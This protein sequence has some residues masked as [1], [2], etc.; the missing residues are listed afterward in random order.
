MTPANIETDKDG[1]LCNREDWSPDIASAIALNEN[2]S[3]TKEHWEIIYLLRDFY[4]EYEISPAMRPLIRYVEK[5]L[6]TEKGKS[7]YLMKLFPESPAKIAS[8]IAG[9]PK[10]TNCL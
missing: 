5:R 10:P 7:I 1:Y 3:L 4:G 8:K 6:G 2:I 9:L